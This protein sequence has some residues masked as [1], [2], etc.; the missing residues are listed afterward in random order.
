[1]TFVKCTV[2]CGPLLQNTQNLV[3]VNENGRVIMIFELIWDSLGIFTPGMSVSAFGH[4]AQALIGREYV[5]TPVL[6]E[7]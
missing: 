1:M 3:T 5:P 6:G 4:S 7:A 2:N